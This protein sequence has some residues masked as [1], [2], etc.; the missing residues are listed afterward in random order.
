VHV[1]T[2][3]ADHVLRTGTLPDHPLLRAAAGDDAPAVEP[4]L[5]APAEHPAIG[6]LRAA[7]LALTHPF[8]PLHADLWQS[9]LPG[10]PDLV[11]GARVALVVGWPEPYDAGVRTTADGDAVLV[12][13]L[14]RI[15]GYGGPEEALAAARQMLDHEIA[16]HVVAATWPPAADPGYADRLDRITF[17]EGIA[18]LLAM[19]EHPLL[20]PGAPGRAAHRAEALDAL[21]QAAALTEPAEQAEALHRADAADGFWDKYACV[22]GLFTLLDADLRGGPAAVAALTAGGWRGFVA[23]VLA[24]GA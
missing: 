19:R 15:A 4:M 13:D 20:A 5:P 14:A 17:D 18:H 9:V 24:G 16:H 21:R 7:L 23:R 12:L 11:A 3:L 8:V 22:A 1:D 10:W 6:A 2:T